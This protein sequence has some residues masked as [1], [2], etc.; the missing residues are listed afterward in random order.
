M[1]ISVNNDSDSKLLVHYYNDNQENYTGAEVSDVWKI[2]ERSSIKNQVA[3]VTGGAQGIGAACAYVLAREGAS[4]VIVDV[5]PSKEILTKI[6]EDFP[7]APTMSLQIDITDRSLVKEGIEKIIRKWKRIDILVNNAGIGSR[8]NLKEMND[9]T[10]E[11]EMAVNLKG[12]YLFT[13][14]CVYPYMESQS[15]G[16]IVNISSISGIVGGANSSSALTGEGRSGPAYASSKG[17]VIAFSKWVAKDVGKLGIYCNVVAPGVIKTALSK[18][19]DYQVENQ[20]IGREGD[21]FDIAEAVLFLS[22]PSSN[23]ITGQVLNVCGGSA[24]G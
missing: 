15:Y 9:D 17:G 7:D 16:K 2:S 6:N 12:T 18:G 14:L 23:Y 3:I 24:I 5:L 10:W 8:T 11:N 20:P 1:A 13:Q 22:S 19:G 4:V 21:P